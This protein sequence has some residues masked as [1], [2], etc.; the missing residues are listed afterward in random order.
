MPKNNKIIGNTQ[1]VEIFKRMKKSLLNKTTKWWWNPHA[2][3]WPLK[4]KREPKFEIIVGVILVQSTSWRNV[5]RALTNL[6][7]KGCLSV[8]AMSRLKLNKLKQLIRP[9]GF[10]AVKARRLKNFLVFLHQKY[11]G[12]LSRLL[13]LPLEQA[14]TELLTVSGIGR[15]SADDILLFAGNR[16]IFPVD[17]YVRRIFSRIGI[18]KRD[19]DYEKVRCFIERRM[20]KKVTKYKEARGLL[21]TLAKEY[22]T[23]RNP[24]CIQCPLKYCC[25]E[26]RKI[27]FSRTQ[28]TS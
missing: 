24:L 22:C 25:K 8:N 14:R 16:C 4:T 1:V 12:H 15:E 17:N 6:A 3:W 2:G 10:Y 20:P 23:K 7:N 9:A 19:T 27:K 13:S 28:Q 5:D 21:I 18:I 26:A 11:K